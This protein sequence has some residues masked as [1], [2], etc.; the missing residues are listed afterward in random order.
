MPLIW[1]SDGLPPKAT[2]AKK[3][4]KTSVRPVGRAGSPL[5]VPE[6]KNSKFFSKCSGN[7]KS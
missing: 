2:E 5:A 1:V 6:F 3:N 7:E 4:E